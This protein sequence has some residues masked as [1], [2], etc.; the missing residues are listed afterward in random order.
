[1]HTVL[2]IEDNPLV[3]TMIQLKLEEAGFKVKCCSDGREGL[4]SLTAE[5]PDIVLT[6][7]MLPYIS[8][9]EILR[10]VKKIKKKDI[11]IIL[12]SSLKQESVVEEAFKLGA[13]DYITKP[14]Q[15]AEIVECVNRLISKAQITYSNG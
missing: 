11:P 8:G 1:M 14:F 5:M 13:D 4:A 12:L 7:I 6:N 9:L 15:M 10:A 2:L 3:S